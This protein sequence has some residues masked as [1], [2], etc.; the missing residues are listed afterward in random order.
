MNELAAH[1]LDLEV[2]L[3]RRTMPVDEVEQVIADDFFEFGRS[4]RRWTRPEIVDMLVRGDEQD[5][6]IDRFEIHQQSPDVVLVTYRSRGEGG[7]WR[8]SLWTHRDSR[9]QL[10]FH[11]GTPST[12]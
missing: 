6:E 4:G 11:Q 7:A 8:S 10:V 1:L 9:W 2:R 3:A 5:L 12:A